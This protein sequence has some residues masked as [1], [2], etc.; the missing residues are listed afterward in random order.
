MEF[1]QRSFRNCEDCKPCSGQMKSWPA[2]TSY[3]EA[4]PKQLGRGL[5]SA[6]FLRQGQL[7]FR[8]QCQLVFSGNRVPR[9]ENMGEPW[10]A[11]HLCPPLTSGPNPIN[12]ISSGSYTQRWVTR[13]H[14][15]GVA[16][17]ETADGGRP[18]GTEGRR[19]SHPDYLSSGNW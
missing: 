15:L 2:C 6:R 11:D 19:R 10:Q 5:G 1:R 16:G 3:K 9:G 12:V 14:D 7:M 17:P 4:K 18:R 8:A 13:H